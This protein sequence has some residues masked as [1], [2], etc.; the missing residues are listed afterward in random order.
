MNRTVLCGIALLLG[1]V[2][3]QGRTVAEGDCPAWLL[4]RASLQDSLR[5]SPTGL[6]PD[7]YSS[8]VFPFVIDP[9]EEIVRIEL[10]EM[11]ATQAQYVLDKSLRENPSAVFIV[12]VT[13]AISVLSEPLSLHDKTCMVLE[14]HGQFVATAGCTS[15]SLLH[16]FDGA[17]VSITGSYDPR[18]GEFSE[19]ENMF[20]GKGVVPGGIRIEQSGRIHLDRIS[21]TGCKDAG[22]SITGR[23][24]ERFDQAVSLTRSVVSNCQGDG[25][26]ICQ[27]PACIVLDS[28]ITSVG[29][30]AL[31]IDS[32]SSI[33]ANTLCSDSNGGVVVCS[34]DGIL[35][36]NQLLRNG[37]GICL[38]DQS[39]Y[40]LVYE[41]SIFDNET[42]IIFEGKRATVGWNLFK[43]KE[44]VIAGG[45]KNILYCNHGILADSIYS[46]GVA[47]FNPPTALNQHHEPFIW[48]N[49]SGDAML[50]A[51]RNVVVD[52]GSQSLDIEEVSKRLSQERLLYPDT[53]LV[54]H[55]R[56][57]FR[58]QCEEGLVLP[59]HTCVI[60]DGKIVNDYVSDNPGTFELIHMKGKGC[61]SFSGGRIISQNKVFAAISGAGASN[62]FLLDGVDV[63]L[64]SE[65]G[66]LG[67]NSVNAVSSKEH[68]GPFVVRGCTI[69]DPGHRGI[70]MHVSK[71]VYALGNQCSAGGFSIDFDAYCFHSAA[72]F[73]TVTRNSY[74]SGIFFEECVKSNTAF[75]NLCE[76]NPA[77]GICMWT[78]NVQG[79][80]E[81]NI[82]A[83][84]EIRGGVQM[85]ANRSGLSLGGRAA[86][87][88]TEN[89][90]FFN[91]RLEDLNGRS[92]ILLKKHARENYITQSIL[93]ENDVDIRNWTSKPETNGFREQAGF[94]SPA[95][96]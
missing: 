94:H 80:T 23:G 48:K 43:N 85:E 32:P 34:T 8:P 17:Y 40:S 68:F 83:C 90:Y 4:P 96:Q 42:G 25:V 24:S 2:V 61:N 37:T 7:F 95:A 35:I 28:R 93:H 15:E 76:K 74:H 78:E 67:S 50:F 88:T 57:A 87:R 31:V 38:E 13:G 3:F 9:N 20:C 63:D 73:N 41:N 39:E 45:S 82:V 33:V 26:R 6:F 65:H 10:K 46:A 30:A 84:N 11:T 44:E 29:K 51:R 47:Y 77:N 58:N 16:V 62:A 60:L 12:H 14:K 86:D 55:M 1:A 81:K 56:G 64:H 70:W 5:Q 75:A 66:G 69:Q 79:K 22:I 89:N 52:A 18:K 49:E 71:R 72:I 54:V 59:D 27:S 53:I 91:N 36:R 19:Q 21:I 92:A